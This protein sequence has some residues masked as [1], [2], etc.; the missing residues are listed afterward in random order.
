MGTKAKTVTGARAKLYVVDASGTPQL[1]GI[2]TNV[3]YGVTYGVTP[4]YILGRF[5]AAE[6]VY[7]DMDVVNVT[8]TGF[9]VME[10]GPYAIGNVPQLQDLLQHEDTSLFIQDRQT[11]DAAKANIMTVTGL[12]TT[13]FDS[14]TSARG[15][16]DLTV[17][18]M[19]TVLKD[20]SGSQ[21]DADAV[22]FG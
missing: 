19:G 5:N 2:F 18:A 21:E 3:S 11:S 7:T 12:R 8:M 9:R 14:T 15:L 13:G 10:N 17:R 4:V 20:E 22:N 16:Q 1:A 6:L